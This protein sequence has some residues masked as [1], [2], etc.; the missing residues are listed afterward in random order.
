[1]ASN[2]DGNIS[3]ESL[4][5]PPASSNVQEPESHV[6]AW[7]EQGHADYDTGLLATRYATFSLDD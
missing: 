3:A 5:V 1:M 6:G 4:V 2:S 7:A